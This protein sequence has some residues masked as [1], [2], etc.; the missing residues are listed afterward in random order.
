MCYCKHKSCHVSKPRSESQYT[1]SRKT[2]QALDVEGD[3]KHGNTG[4]SDDD[5]EKYNELYDKLLLAADRVLCGAAFNNKLLNAFREER[6]AQHRKRPVQGERSGKAQRSSMM[7]KDV[8]MKDFDTTHLNALFG[9]GTLRD[10]HL[11]EQI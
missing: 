4:W 8:D 1:F 5:I 2:K 11:S 9:S 7:P 10:C 3:T 6:R